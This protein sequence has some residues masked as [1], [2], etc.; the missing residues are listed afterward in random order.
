MLNI[1]SYCFIE[2][3]ELKCLRINF[4]QIALKKFVLV[5][6]IMKKVENYFKSHTASFFTI[7][8]SPSA[9]HFFFRSVIS[10][11]SDRENNNKDKTEKNV[12][13]KSNQTE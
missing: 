9:A 10:F 7:S 13:L 8:Y 11:A 4:D 3:N 2:S 5:E 12:K 6:M 1:F